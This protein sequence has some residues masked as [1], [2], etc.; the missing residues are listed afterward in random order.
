MNDAPRIAPS[1]KRRALDQRQQESASKLARVSSST[2][3][4]SHVAAANC[5]Y[6]KF[7][8]ALGCVYKYV[9][10]SA[11]SDIRRVSFLSFRGGEN[12]MVSEM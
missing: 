12:C 9:V 7:H 10:D 2:R 8:D 6:M 5:V 11:I 4:N 1:I 3:C